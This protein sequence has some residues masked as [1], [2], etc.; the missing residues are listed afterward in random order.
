MTGELHLEAASMTALAVEELHKIYRVK[1]SDERG[2]T[3]DG[4]IPKRD[5]V[6]YPNDPANAPGAVEGGD[7]ISVVLSVLE[8]LDNIV[9]GDNTNGNIAGRH[10]EM[11]Q[12]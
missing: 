8:E 12:F 11:D 10:F 6:N 3:R 5:T 2:N 7:G 9:S 1:V 4:F